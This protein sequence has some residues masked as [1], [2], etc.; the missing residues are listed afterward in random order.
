MY[1]VNSITGLDNLWALTSGGPE[2]LV[3]ILDGPVDLTHP[4]LRGA[5]LRDIST[6]CVPKSSGVRSRHGT[7]VTS[8]IF[9]QGA[10]GV[11]GIAPRCRGILVS[12]FGLDD[13]DQEPRC[14]QID[15]ARA[16]SVATTNGADII[17][18]SGGE[19]S[20]SGT[21]HP[22]LADT[23]NACAR[24]GKG[25]LHEYITG[26][27][28]ENL[29]VVSGDT[30]PGPGELHKGQRLRWELTGD[31]GIVLQPGT[32][33]AF[34]VM[35]DEPSAHRE[36][37]LANLYHGPADI[38]G[39]GIRRE[40]S[41]AEPWLDPSWVN[42]RQASSLPLDRARRLEQRA[43]TWGRPD[44]DTFRVLTFYLEGIQ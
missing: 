4:A 13:S 23:I 12:I 7:H 1:I 42:N 34:L 32:K 22:I 25:T 14:S 40:G 41:V 16:I 44:V 8:V 19:F 33:Y 24:R 30:L 27:T 35:F 20:P 38:G 28:Y 11:R 39:H 21:A 2:V 15:L 36:L 26:E 3:A 17:N 31:N 6:I 10:G 18:I 9:G 29:G 5:D 43:G 37:A